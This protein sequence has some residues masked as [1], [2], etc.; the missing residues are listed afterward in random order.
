MRIKQRLTMSCDQCLKTNFLGDR[1]DHH[2]RKW[3]LHLIHNEHYVTSKHV[4][5]K[6]LMIKIRR[7]VS[8]MLSLSDKNIKLVEILELIANLLRSILQQSLKVHGLI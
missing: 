2:D 3:I 5:D 4:N 6:Y 8:L 1:K 7:R